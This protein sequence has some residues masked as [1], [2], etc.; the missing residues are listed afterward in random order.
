MTGSESA[1][2]WRKPAR[3]RTARGRSKGARTGGTEGQVIVRTT[4]GELKRVSVYGRS[5]E[6]CDEKIT[7]LKA[8]NYAGIGASVSSYTDEPYL[9][10][11]AVSVSRASPARPWTDGAWYQRIGH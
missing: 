5:W 9:A 11:R 6:E 2:R 10:S 7:R 4:S 1:S 3:R 8:D